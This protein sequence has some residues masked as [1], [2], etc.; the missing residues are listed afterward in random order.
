[1]DLNK[2]IHNNQLSGTILFLSFTYLYIKL[3]RKSSCKT[4]K[5][6]DSIHVSELWIYPIKSCKGIK[7]SSAEVTRRGFKHDRMLMVVDSNGRFYSQRKDPRLSLVSTSISTLSKDNEYIDILTIK[8]PNMQEL[9]IDLSSRLNGPILEVEIWSDKCEAFEILDG[10][11]WFRE[12]LDKEG[13][14]LVRMKDDFT[15]FTDPK[16]SPDGET[17]FSDGFPF[18]IASQA[19]INDLNKKLKTKIT[20][21]NFRPNIIV[22]GCDAFAEDTWKSIEVV[23]M[24]ES[25]K[26]NVVKPCSRCQIPSIDPNKGTKY[27]TNEVNQVMKSYRTGAVLNLEKESWKGEVLIFST[28]FLHVFNLLH[29]VI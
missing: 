14:R 28:T 25:L 6:N 16:Y 24:N 3:L 13:L 29:S 10:S 21:E 11:F 22:D 26:F 18:L 5:A 1:M 20:M 15:R 23:N 2:I 12:Y 7:V 19:S 17:S 4:I 8:A 9:S 27:P